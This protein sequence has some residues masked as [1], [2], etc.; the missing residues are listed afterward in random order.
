MFVMPNFLGQRYD[1]VSASET[2][3]ERLVFEVTYDYSDEYDDGLICEQDIEEGTTLYPIQTVKIIVSKG[4][5]TVDIPD[6]FDENGFRM[7]A[8]QYTAI[9]DSLNIK[10]EYRKVETPYEA[11]GYVMG[12]FCPETGG[13]VGGKINVAEGNTLYVDVSEFTPTVGPVG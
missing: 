12:V 1:S 5:S 4:L 13:E 10:Y 11:T 3:K 7:T 2:W 9:L 8:E 6:F